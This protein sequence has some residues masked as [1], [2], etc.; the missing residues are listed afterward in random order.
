MPK[1]IEHFEIMQTI[2]SLRPLIPLAI[3]LV[4]GGAGATLY[5][6]SMPAA[7]GSPE[8]RAQKLE[9]DLKRANIRIAALE[10]SMPESRRR[11]TLTVTDRLRDLGQ[12]IRDGRPV[13]PDDIFRACQPLLRDLAPLFDRMR[14]RNGQRTID[15]R[16]GEMARKYN[17]NA[18]QQE[19]LK[20]WF[21]QKAE[22]DAK[23]W[24]AL[25]TQEG[26]RIEDMMRAS[27]DA[28]PDEGL[29]RFMENMLSGQDLAKFKTER[30]NEKAQRVQQ[31][32]DMKVER[33]NKIVSLDAEQTD[34]VFGI[35][36][37]SSK[38][39]DPALRIEGTDGRA[40]SSVGDSREAMLSVLRPDQRAAYDAE[41]QRR[42][43]E[44][45]KDLEAIGL[46][47]PADW[48]PL[49]DF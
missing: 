42:R 36:A 10:G 39:Y 16:V 11:P 6:N 12:N 48:D 15:S 34:K 22:D 1:V 31:Y 14:V 30:I 2:L 21:R 7:A 18:A 41:Q 23:A 3:G 20:Q 38:D 26:T 37:R 17:L 4:L 5:R 13:S 27:R 33:L 46:K 43:D 35:M 9:S 32:A 8:E 25:V 45:S 47:L 19:S 24:T 40:L 28:R 49:D 29:Y 44:A